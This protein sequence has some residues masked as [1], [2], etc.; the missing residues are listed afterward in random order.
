M[1]KKI[2]VIGIIALIVDQLSKI[3]VGSFI[4]SNDVVVIIEDFF[5]IVNVENSGAAFSILEG[6]TMMLMVLSVFAIV[7]L[8]KLSKDFI[9]NKRNMVAFGLLLGGIFGN[10]GDRLFLGVV[11]DFLKFKIFGYNFPIFNVADMCIV[12]GVFLLLIS[13]FKGEDKNGSSSKSR[14]VSKVRQVS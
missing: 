4:G 11:R 6:R 13:M 3:L 10:F 1:N 14:G 7:A 12:V 2:F 5:Y 9:E 8:L